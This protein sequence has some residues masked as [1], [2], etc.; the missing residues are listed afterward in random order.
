MPEDH[1]HREPVATEVDALRH[2]VAELEQRIATAEARA[3]NERAARRQA[4]QSRGEGEQRYRL[5]AEHAHDKIARHTPDGVYLY[6]SPASRRLLGYEPAEL[7]GHS[8]FEKIHP[9][10]IQRVQQAMN[11]LVQNQNEVST[12]YRLRHREGHYVWLETISKAITDA[13]TGQ[14]IEII[15][16]S[17]DVTQHH[18]AEQ[19]LRLVQ[20]AIEQVG[21]AVVITEPELDLPGPRILYVNRAFTQMTGYSREEVIGKTPRILQGPET[22]R[23]ELDR[24][25]QTLARGE[26]FEGQTYNYRKDG[27]RFILHWHVTPIRDDSRRITHFVSIQRDVTEQQRAERLARQREAELAHVGRLSTMGQMA[28]ELAHE[29]NQPLAA[30]G[31]YVQGGLRRL[32]DGRVSLE[33]LDELLSRVDTQ[34]QRAGQ[35][36]RRMRQFV[37]K[38]EPERTQVELRTLVEEVVELVEPEL[39]HQ[40]INLELD[41]ADDLPTTVLDAIQIE[42]VILNLVRNAIDAMTT[43]EPARR[44]LAI[45]TRRA[46]EGQ[47]A[48]E[49]RDT[50]TG[51]SEADLKQVFE[52]FYS[53]KS[54]GMGMGLTISRTIV[55][56]HGGKLTV[57]PNIDTGVCFTITLPL[58]APHA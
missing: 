25:K 32:R 40:M 2:R 35:I 8:A 43:V 56:T 47:V 51:I 7:V 4:E 16:V 49:V 50:G 10:D 1:A 45:R 39:R 12:V 11:A 14:L 22:S 44:R 6:V 20:A 30:I 21:E 57:T 23:R 46:A 5:L 31:S 37:R 38:R 13:D 52:P 3:R 18:Q 28:S 26:R 15:S 48:L 34:A 58:H 27:E 9:D 55:Q 29:L 17:R 36:I 41:F 54:R 19:N 53:T 42:Q 24:L 33:D